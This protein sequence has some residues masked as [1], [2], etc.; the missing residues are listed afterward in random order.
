MRFVEDRIVK[1]EDDVGI[2][3]DTLHFIGIDLVIVSIEKED[4]PVI[5]RRILRE[6]A[7]DIL[8]VY[9]EFTNSIL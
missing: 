9:G 3:A 5:L 8:I 7:V 2:L 4:A 6:K 1:I